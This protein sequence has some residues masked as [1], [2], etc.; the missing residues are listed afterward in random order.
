MK[1]RENCIQGPG[2][3]LC[4]RAPYFPLESC[5]PVLIEG[6]HYE[7]INVVEL[8]QEGCWLCVKLL[9]LS[10]QYVHYDLS[11]LILVSLLEGQLGGTLGW[12]SL[13]CII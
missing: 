11:S 9:W 13:M 6:L 8:D 1:E 7:K 5:N 2:T 12:S 10:S 4:G 3:N